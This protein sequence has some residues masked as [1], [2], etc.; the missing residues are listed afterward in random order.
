MFKNPLFRSFWMQAGLKLLAWE[1]ALIAIV[2]LGNRLVG[3]LQRFR[4]SDL[5]FVAGVIV[6]MAA[7]ATLSRTNEAVPLP[8]RG[9][10]VLSVQAT[11]QE[12]R[13]Q[14]LAESLQRGH[15]AAV[16]GVAILL[17]VVLTFAFH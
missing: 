6:L 14:S 17:A 1:A 7:V 13:E 12:Q 8:G 3:G 15:L 16:G 9:V 2:W 11:E 4:F 10:S 5:L